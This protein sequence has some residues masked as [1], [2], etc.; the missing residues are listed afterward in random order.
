VGVDVTRKAESRE[1]VIEGLYMVHYDALYALQSSQPNLP[2]FLLQTVLENTED[3]F[4]N[5]W[6]S[7]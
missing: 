2:R 3:Q 6:R 5:Q 7:K 4:D 1:L